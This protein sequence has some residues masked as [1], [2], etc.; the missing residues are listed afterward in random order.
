MPACEMTHL[1]REPIDVDRAAA[2]HAAYEEVL[3]RLGFTIFQLEAQPDLPDSVFVEDTAVVLD[4]LAVITRP[5]APSRRPETLSI[6]EALA[7]IRPI[8]QMTEPATLDGGDVL[9]LGTRVFVGQ[10][11][12]TNENGVVQLQQLVEP[13]GYTVVAVPVT[14]C[15]H[16]KSAVTEVGPGTLL[17]NPRWVP[18]DLF[19]AYRLI[20]VDPRE[21]LGANALLAG[22]PVIYSHSSPATAERLLA[23]GIDLR[24]LDM[25]EMEKAD[26]AVTCCSLL[27]R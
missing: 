23:R 8:A 16:L 11:T 21:P 26:G 19:A 6:A 25:S 3:D 27:I 13:F 1:P 7:P 17:I 14:G 2:Q 5:G 4:E 15:L 12:R 20:E 10:S 18:A 24:L 22:G 9:Q